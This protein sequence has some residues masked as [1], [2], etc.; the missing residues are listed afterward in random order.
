MNRLLIVGAL[1]ISTAPLLA[2]GQQP[3]VAK[4]KADARNL[5]G[6]IGSDRTKT[7]TYCKMMDL[8]WQMNEAAREKGQKKRA[9]TLS[10][11]IIQLGK[12]LPEFVVLENIL[13]DIDLK[14]TDGR[15]IALI[16]QSLNQSCPD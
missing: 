5:V 4:L 15:E 1:I 9:K 13:G 16:I 10:E 12:R 8:S 3:N 7:R 11:E 6:I 2:Q 14:S